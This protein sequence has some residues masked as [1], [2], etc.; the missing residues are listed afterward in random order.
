VTDGDRYRLAFLDWLACA[1]RGMREQPARAARAAADGLA[2]RVTAAGCAGH[3]LDYDDTYAAGLVHASAPV[4]PVALLLA[5]HRDLKLAALLG[6]YAAGFEATAALAR[7]SHPDLYE[8]GWHPTAVC[9][10]VGAAVTASRLLELDPERERTAAGLALLRAGGLQ[11]SFGTDGK[12]LQVG[13]AAATG[14]EAARL[15]AAGARLTRDAVIAGFESAYGATWAAPRDEPAIRENWIKAHPCCLMTHAAIDAAE[16]LRSAGRVPAGELVLAVHP[17]AR[18]AAPHD[19]A[20]DGLQA[21]FSIPYTTAHTLL[22]GPPNVESFAVPDT[23]ARSFASERI[24]VRID[25]RLLETE[26]RLEAD[27]QVVAAVAHARGSP[28][29]PMD[30]A[31]LAQKV[32]RLAPGLSGALADADAPARDVAGLARLL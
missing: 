5:A 32:D 29:D 18:R 26:A 11:A 31:A 13:L 16:Q 12:A 21:K 8:R 6:A 7:A 19:D 22:H 1:A 28:Q 3:V 27:G 4:A 30:S 2:G 25:E 17:T 9:G 24:R 23:A 20:A 15:S 14:L 10:P